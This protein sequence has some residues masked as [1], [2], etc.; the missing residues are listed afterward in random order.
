MAEIGTYL[1]LTDFALLLFDFRRGFTR[2]P[3]LFAATAKK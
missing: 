1:V 2:A 3:S